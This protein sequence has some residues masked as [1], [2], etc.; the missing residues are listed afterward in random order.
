VKLS[1]R[2]LGV[3]LPA[4]AAAATA[5]PEDKKMVV[6]R[7][8]KYADLPVK[9]NGPNTAR[10]VFDGATHAG[11]HID[12]HL[13]EL[14][15]GQAPHPPHKHVHEELLMLQTGVLDV[16]IGGATIRITPGSVVYAASGQEHGWRNPG[17][18]P[19]QYFVLALGRE[20]A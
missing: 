10:D 6:A 4:L 15:P 2:N 8:F 12:M 3:L 18:A 17:T 16:T 9:P 7:V 1:R 13:T 19:A 11:F 20:D 5:A 14:G